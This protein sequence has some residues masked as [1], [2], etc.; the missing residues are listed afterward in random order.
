MDPLRLLM[1]LSLLS[2]VAAAPALAGGLVVAPL[3][4]AIGANTAQPSV[5]VDPGRGFI[6]TWQQREG[7]RT[8]L[9]FLAVGRDGRTG[10]RGTIAESARSGPGRT[11]ARWFVNW[12]DFPSLVVLDNGDWVSHWLQKDGAGGDAYG[13]QVTRSRDRGRNWSA[14][15]SPHTDG[16]PTEHGFVSLLPAGGDRVRLVWLDGRDTLAAAGHEAHA[17]HAAHGTMSLRSAVLDRRGLL[18]EEARLDADTCSCCQTDAVRVGARSVVAY[19]DVADGDLRNMHWLQHAAGHWSPDE[20]LHDDGWRIAG[21]PVNGPALAAGKG[22]VFALWP[23]MDGER[24]R[25]RMALDR[26]S[27]F[28]APAEL[29]EGTGVIGRVDAAAWGNDRFLAVWMGAGASSVGSALRLALVD[30]TLAVPESH[31]LAAM[32]AG[33]SSG[34]PRMAAEGG[35]AL[36]AWVEAGEGGSTIRAVVIRADEK[37]APGSAVPGRP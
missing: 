7:E 17:G 12:A 5:A 11:P 16:T 35:M 26:G 33:R 23:T 37:L 2:C 30:G 27:G 15:Q 24:M 4:L 32:P 21:C 6:V 1:Q 19:R 34:L 13:I 36:V 22:R 10:R 25:V 8:V 18:S 3:D 28:G 31:T 20:V 14:P 29:D 9:S